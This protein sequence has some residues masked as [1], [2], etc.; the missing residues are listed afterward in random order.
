M[1]CIRQHNFHSMKVF[2]APITKWIAAHEAELKLEENVFFRFYI[3]FFFK[4]IFWEMHTFS[5]FAHFYWFVLRYFIL[6][7]YSNLNTHLSFDFCDILAIIFNNLLKYFFFSIFK[8]C[9]FAL[10]EIAVLVFQ[11]I[12][13]RHNFFNRQIIGIFDDVNSKN[14]ID[15]WG[16]PIPNCLVQISSSFFNV[17]CKFVPKTLKH[18]TIY[19]R[20]I[21]ITDHVST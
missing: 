5:L 10:I 19:I 16:N 8:Y 2:Y 18:S 9:K 20:I 7:N 14:E 11:L 6:W 1:Q 17:C 15:P 4:L 12:W 21:I 3:S 13:S